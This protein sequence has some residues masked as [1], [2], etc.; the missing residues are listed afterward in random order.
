MELHDAEEAMRM[1]K[2]LA[3][4]IRK[5]STIQEGCFLDFYRYSG[6]YAGPKSNLHSHKEIS[7][8]ASLTPKSSICC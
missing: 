3:G 1:R 4:D 6:S 5:E 8:M 7:S 2:I